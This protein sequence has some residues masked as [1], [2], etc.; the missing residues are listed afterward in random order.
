M[1]V[2][3][4]RKWEGKKKQQ[5][6]KVTLELF[7]LNIVYSTEIRN[8]SVNQHGI[9]E[10]WQE[11]ELGVNYNLLKWN[12]KRTG[13]S[14]CITLHPAGLPPDRCTYFL[15][16][17]TIV[18]RRSIDPSVCASRWE[19]FFICL[20]GAAAHTHSER[21]K[22]LVIGRLRQRA[23]WHRVTRTSHSSLINTQ[24]TGEPEDANR[25]TVL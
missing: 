15:M 22:I 23:P 18:H 6:K 24:S 3:L 21:N 7:S 5:I 1:T 11:W 25:D 2:K 17:S 12:L 20:W 16:S 8:M 4:D 14:L 13:Y 19:I 9:T 10:K